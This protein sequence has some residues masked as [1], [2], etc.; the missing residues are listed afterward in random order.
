MKKLLVLVMSCM[1]MFA[2]VA[3]G[4]KAEDEQTPAENKVDAEAGN[5]GDENQSE[6]AD[7]SLD[8]IKE[9]GT[10]V[11]GLDDSFPPMGFRDDNNNIIGFDIDLANEVANILGVKLELQPIAW[12]AKEH[13]LSTKNIDVIWNG[14][15]ITPDRLENMTMSEP[16]LEN[17]IAVVVKKDSDIT[18]LA[19]LAGKNVAV[20]SA[21]AAEEALLSDKNKEFK[22]SLG[23]VNGLENYVTALM[24]LE[25]GN[26]D[27]VLMDSVVALYF[28]LQES[29][30]FVLLD[31]TLLA[32][33][34]A[35][36]FRKGEEAFASAVQEALSELKANGK[37]AEISTKWF[38]SDITTIQ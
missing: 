35:I 11:L 33:E 13:E 8:Y 18:T 2:M 24:E 37:V 9:K 34:Y 15:S 31:E 6:E 21:S 14:M 12:S 29:K 16:Y 27:A 3:C 30:D 5:N 4:T 32:D 7:V 17:D 38:G 28:I 26:S 25:T 23:E 20:Q 36:G 1:L 19:D 10:L 22:D